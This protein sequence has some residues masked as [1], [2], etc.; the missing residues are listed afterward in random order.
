MAL[1]KDKH[2]N[3]GVPESLLDDSDFLREIVST[4]LQ[5]V[6]DTEVAEHIGADRYERTTGRKGY[7]NG[8]YPRTLKTRVGRIELSVPRDR[9]GTFQT[10]LF[11]RYQRNEKALILALMEMTLEGVSTRKVTKI[12]EELCGTSF[13]KSLVSSLSANLDEQLESWRNR[14]LE[15]DYPY[16][17]VDALY[18]KVRF[19]GH[20]RSMAVIIVVGVNEDGYRSVL[21]VD[22]SH[23]ENAADY[24]DIFRKLRERGLSGVQ[25]VA[26]DDHSGLVQAI[27]R[28]FQG[29]TWQ[30]CQVHFMRN[31]SSKL[32][33]KDRTWVL[34]AMKDVLAAPDHAQAM[35]RFQTLIKRLE[36]KYSDLADWLEDSMPDVLACLSFPAAHF[37]R[38]RSTNGLERLNEEIRRRTRVIRI[39]PNRASCLRMASA[40]CQEQDEEWLTGKRYLDISLLK[41]TKEDGGADKIQRAI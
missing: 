29:A 39:F 6:L 5:N 12:T 9:D 7:R 23:S 4:V 27:S 2:K 21:S 31:L 40:L 30:R 20:V 41:E 37:H 26:S 16:I 3:A 24:G 28:H 35:S 25:L 38:I 1:Q 17:F 8:S 36:V 19:D 34:S 22:I 32:R 15:G 18:E 33:Q 11:T 10:S 14:P 13:S